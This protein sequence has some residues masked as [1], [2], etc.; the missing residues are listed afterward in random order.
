MFISLPVNYHECL[1]SGVY[2][3]WMISCNGCGGDV[4][5]QKS[6]FESMPRCE[7]DVTC[8][9]MPLETADVCGEKNW[10]VHEILCLRK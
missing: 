1:P 5:E 9:C 4:C 10:D 6:L 3:L 2:T 8:V 7:G